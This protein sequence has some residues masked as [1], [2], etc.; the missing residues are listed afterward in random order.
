MDSSQSLP[1]LEHDLRHKMRDLV[2]LSTLSSLWTGYDAI[3]IAG[4]LADVLREML[5]L[6]FIYIRLWNPRG[7]TPIE[8]ARDSTGADSLAAIL[9]IGRLFSPIPSFG[10]I[11]SVADNPIR[12][13]RVWTT[14]VP[15]GREGDLGVIVSASQ[16]QSFPTESERL[17]L[18]VAANQTAVIIG[19]EQAAQQANA[20]RNRWRELLQQ[21]PAAVAVLRG[22]DHIFELVNPE[23]ER[24]TGRSAS[25]L[26]GRSIRVAIPE[27]ADQGFVDLL[28]DVYKTG[29]PAFGSERLVKLKRNKRNLEHRFFNFAYQPARSANGVIEGVFVHAVDVTEQV[30]ARRRVE[31]SEQQLSTL[32]NSIP[33]LTWMAEPDGHIFWYNQRWYDYTGTSPDQ[34]KAQGWN[35]FHDPNKLPVVLHRWQYSVET[36]TPFEMEF[37]LVGANGEFKWFLTRIIP[38]R[39]TEGVIIRWFGTG[40]DVTELKRIRDERAVLL[41]Q[42]QEA[43]GTAELLNS[44]GPTLLSELDLN[45]LVQAVTD[46]ATTLTGAEFGAFFHNVIGKD[47]ESYTLYTLSGVSREAFK[48]FPMPRNTAVFG[49]TFKGEGVV[50]SDNITKDPRYGKAAPYYGMPKGHLP[51]VS[52]LAAPVISRSGNVLGGLFFGHSLPA[53]FTMRHEAIVMGIAAQAA[54]AMDNAQLFEKAQRVQQQ[55][56][57]SN[58]ELRRANRDLESFAY[59]ASHDLQEPLRNVAIYSQLLNQQY[60]GRLEPDAETFLSGILGGALRMEALIKDLLAYC[61][62]TKTID[63]APPVIDSGAVLNEV[64]KNL[65]ASIEENMA[66]ITCDELPRISIQ[67]IHLSQLFMNLISNALKYRSKE[68]SPRV[69]ISAIDQNDNW[70]FSVSDNGIGIDPQYHTQIFGL[71]KRLHTSSEYQG[72]GMGLAICQ[73]I[74]EQYGGRI[75][76][77]SGCGR[78]SLFRFTVPCRAE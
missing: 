2:A 50:R 67:E 62:A 66:V 4:S 17:L 49:P 5:D 9:P 22:P 46:L 76:V 18:T 42:E 1:R 63:G 38:L 27:I 33:Q 45:K 32:A 10:T 47:G 65:S 13:G 43:R 35:A 34:M 21:A 72:S 16:R 48:D 57:H 23:Y 11:P 74:L 73:R 29:R 60:S 69:H 44:I 54:I 8:I 7:T 39:N 59:S 53:R 6:E 40:T 64:L 14:A 31:E 51:V 37:P 41:A 15:I 24:A 58:E 12:K 28:D 77:E 26:L 61:Q 55:L 25:H 19:H 56:E 36:G 78:G 52:Y 30:V 71:F 3:R 75:W 70:V 20:E 68:H